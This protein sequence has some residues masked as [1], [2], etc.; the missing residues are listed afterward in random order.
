MQEKDVI[1]RELVCT[2][3]V[4]G[5]GFRWFARQTA[6]LLEVTGWAENLPD[7]AVKVQVQGQ[8]GRVEAFIERL[9][10]GRGWI[11]VDGISQKPLPLEDE[12]GFEA[13]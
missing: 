9:Q 8:R 6:S 2:G 1:R 7:G 5:V 3:S 12:Y 11:E 13:R 4:Q 10:A